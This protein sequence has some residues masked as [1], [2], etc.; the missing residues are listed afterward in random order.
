MKTT[1]YNSTAQGFT[2]IEL[3]IVLVIIGL[4]VG[5]VLVGRDLINASYVRA[6][7]SQIEKYQTAANTFRGKYNNYLPG[8]IPEPDASRFGFLT[9][10]Q[11]NAQGDGN[12][13]LEGSWA[14][15]QGYNRM[16][17]KNGENA[18][19]WRDL[20]TA[21]LV[22]GT[23]SY[24]AT[25]LDA[26]YGVTTETTTPSVQDFMPAGKI[27]NSNYVYVYGFIDADAGFVSKGI[28]YFG[29][30]SVTTLTGPGETYDTPSL[31]LT[32]AQAR[33]IDAKMD[34]GLPQT[35]NVQATF[36]GGNYVRWASGTSASGVYGTADTAVTAP[37]A[38]T[39][40]DNNSVAGAVQ[41]YS[42]NQ[43]G[44]KMPNCALSFKFQ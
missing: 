31:A 3:S 41:Q 4:I 33:A 12:G 13:A 43:N 18:M 17:F 9:R 21:K 29:L 27:G 6:Q 37:S 7:I 42:V 20:A 30:M 35:G 16:V 32:V 2:L 11:Y 36:V 1:A 23:F 39:C 25:Y 26:Y 44:G 28:N 14:N 24:A 34:D 40:Y 5:G 15:L 19:F 8:D 10:G 22:E 38:T